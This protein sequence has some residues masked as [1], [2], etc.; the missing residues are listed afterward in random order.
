MF[1]ESPKVR[2]NVYLGTVVIDEILI[3]N[4]RAEM[5]NAQANVNMMASQALDALNDCLAMPDSSNKDQVV[6]GLQA[7]YEAA[8]ALVHQQVQMQNDFNAQVS[9]WGLGKIQQVPGKVQGLGFVVPVVPIATTISIA[10]LT[11]LG[12]YVAK[13]FIAAYEPEAAA[14]NSWIAYYSTVRQCLAAGAACSNIPA[15]PSGLLGGSTDWVTMGLIGGI[16]VLVILLI[17][18]KR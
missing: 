10:A 3:A 11:A 1:S 2:T 5:D 18:G 17:T 4:A 8:I 15:P 14:H 6:S 13:A 9:S 7:N 12:I 16:G